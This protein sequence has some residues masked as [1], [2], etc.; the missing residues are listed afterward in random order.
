MPTPEVISQK[1]NQQSLWLLSFAIAMLTTLSL[2]LS[3]GFLLI[4]TELNSHTSQIIR[5]TPEQVVVIMPDAQPTRQTPEA[6]T[7]PP[8][9]SKPSFARTSADQSSTPP[10]RADFIGE[11]DT[12][13]T[14][15]ALPVAGAPEMPSQ[16]GREPRRP[17]EIETTESQ[18]QDGTLEHNRIAQNAPS[19]TPPQPATAMP[20]DR[21]SEKPEQQSPTPADATAPSPSPVEGKSAAMAS[22]DTPS[23]PGDQAVERPAAEEMT[24]K[25]QIA[26]QSAQETTEKTETSKAELPKPTPPNKPEDQGFRGNQ[27]KTKLSGSIT[28]KGRSALNVANTPMGRYHSALSRAVES[29]WHKNCT[30]YRDFIT[31]GILTVRFVIAPDSSVRTISVVEMID[32]GE[33]Q[34]GFTLSSIRQ[35]KIP[36]IPSD[37]KAEIEDE[38]IELIYNFYF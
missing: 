7:P 23:L 6:E 38:P 3:I 31:P 11:R 25:P 29:E 22:A 9:P 4:R 13:A 34:K 12:I 14:S 21:P 17:G 1:K 33:V 2:F 37:L 32:A 27:T 28:R 24:P 16:A 18:V 36:P 15:D 19:P 5:P 30:K 10:E 35:A 8:P 26:E 20:T